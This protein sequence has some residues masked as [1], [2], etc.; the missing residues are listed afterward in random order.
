MIDREFDDEQIPAAL[1]AGLAVEVPP[2]PEDLGQNVHQRVNRLLL[3]SQLFEFMFRALPWAAAMLLSPI[4]HL[5]VY[6]VSGQP[7]H[8]AG[9][10]EFSKK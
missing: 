5:I 2:I 7:L 1:A 8:S 4:L 10:D 6:T 9:D 3:T